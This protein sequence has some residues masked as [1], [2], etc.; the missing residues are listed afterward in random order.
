MLLEA[1]RHGTSHVGFHVRVATV[2]SRRRRLTSAQSV[3]SQDSQDKKGK[4]NERE[5]C[6]KKTILS[7]QLLKLLIFSLKPF[8]S[9]FE[10]LQGSL[11]VQL[12]CGHRFHAPCA[13]WQPF[14]RIVWQ[15]A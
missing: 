8:F 15:E 4:R 5:K 6:K 10:D 9:G 11:L 1:A 14:A 7:Q 12:P 13:A 2:R 3:L